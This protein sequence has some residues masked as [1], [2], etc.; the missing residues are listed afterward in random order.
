MSKV[1]MADAVSLDGYL[2]D[3]DDAGGPLFDWYAN[4]DS[5]VVVNGQKTEFRTS[6][7][8]AEFGPCGPSGARR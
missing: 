2:A 8:T 7:Q 4:G 5:P 6:P 1:I 3:D